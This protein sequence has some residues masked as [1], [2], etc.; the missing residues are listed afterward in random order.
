V[1][2][3]HF[4][5]NTTAT[6][7]WKG[8]VI[9]MA[10]KILQK[11]VPIGTAAAL[12]LCA[13]IGSWHSGAATISQGTAF[14]RYD[15][16]YA[17]AVIYGDG[18]QT[19]IWW[20]GG[21]GSGDAIYYATSTSSGWSTPVKVLEKSAA[22]WDSYHTCD[23]SV[24]KGAFQ[25][26]GQ[27]YTYAMYYTGTY[28]AIGYDSHIGVAFSNDGIHWTKYGAPVVGPSSDA[29]RQYGTGMQ[30]VYRSASGLITMMYFDST[31]NKNYM[32]T[33]TDGINFTNKTLLPSHF[34]N[35]HSGDIAFSPTENKWYIT[36]K[37]GTDEE[38][39][40]YESVD[41]NLAGTWEW[42]GTISKATT[43]KVKNHNPGWMRYPGGD[44]YIE[45][46]TGYKYIY[47]GAGSAST[48]T[49]DIARSIYTTGW[50]FSINGNRQGWT[51]ANI[52]NDTGPVDGF[53]IFVTNQ[54][55]PYL[56]SP[57]L[58]AP[59]AAFSTVSVRIAN[60]NTNSQGKIYFKTASENFYSEDKSVS[61]TCTAGGGWYTHNVNMST[62]AKWTGTITGIRVD[63][64]AE[65]TV[66]AC[67]VDF[68]RLIK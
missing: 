2:R 11:L 52:A 42:T 55:D 25:M 37:S 20:G 48:A 29:S 24:I 6:N 9:N 44:I 53:W 18:P 27:A 1:A 23:P 68:I 51:S 16:D 45:S 49:W 62:N 56:T 58:E 21:T 46:G 34:T 60:Q 32:V 7:L 8:K 14:T 19:K 28:D 13:L 57:A 5:F 43:G 38:I 36:T 50:E 64:V 47:Y 31:T 39:Y 33:S 59:A 41:S 35:E 40:I 67:G 30:S 61:F 15:F 54:N 63:P 66:A 4:G 12:L 65:G 17:P 3:R 22:G 10:K 26:N